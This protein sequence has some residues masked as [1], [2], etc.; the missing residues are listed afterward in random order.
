M[1]HSLFSA[2]H[3]HAAMRTGEIRELITFE[4]DIPATE[5]ATP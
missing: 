1:R 2:I 4:S 3:D 5:N